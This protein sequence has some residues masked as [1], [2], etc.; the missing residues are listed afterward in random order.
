M[1]WALLAGQSPAAL[2]VCKEVESWTGAG[3][4]CPRAQVEAHSYLS[5]ERFADACLYIGR[6]FQKDSEKRVGILWKHC[7][8]RC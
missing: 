7:A 2:Q 6:T 1:L 4:I 8:V 5:L 3:H